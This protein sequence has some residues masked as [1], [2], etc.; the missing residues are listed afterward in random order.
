MKAVMFVPRAEGAAV[1][2][3]E[4]PAPVPAAGEALVRVLAAG[5]NR[6]ELIAR[7]SLTSGTAQQT[8]I[9]FAGEVAAL[10][11]D[12]SRF[13]PG[14]GVMGHWRGGQAQFVAAD[15]RLLV[16]VPPRLTWVQAAAWLN[17][18]VTAHDAIVTNAQLKRG[19][20]ILINAASSGIGV[21][22]LQIARFLGA[23]PVIGSSRSSAKR[24]LLGQYGMQVGIE[25]GSAS[26]ADTIAQA[27]GN[28]GV[29]V[30]IDSVGGSGF[31]RNL[32]AMALCG[33]I[34]SVG[35]LAG[36]VGNIDLD[37]LALKRIKLIGV[38]FRTRTK[39][40]R[41]ACVQRCAADLWEALADGRLQPVVHRAF[42]MD[43]VNAAHEYME[44]DKHIGKL[45]IQIPH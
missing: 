8:G 17:V 36:N 29:D 32:E 3:R 4:V 1:E 2:V 26:A 13:K 18:F 38:T 44:K 11:P 30:L 28:K 10:G 5:L 20:A 25:A 15:E 43:E 7:R 27:T 42:P 14:D 19:E 34:V 33:R 40:E 37:L 35:R 9:E 41:I 31:N 12:A 39:E 22:A 23:N 6:G 21:A 16:P 45:V 24:E